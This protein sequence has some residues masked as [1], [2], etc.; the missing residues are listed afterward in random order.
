MR[1]FVRSHRSGVFIALVM[2]LFWIYAAIGVATFLIWDPARTSEAALLAVMLTLV[3]SY[4]FPWA[5]ITETWLKIRKSTRPSAHWDW[6]PDTS[7]PVDEARMTTDSEFG[8]D[9]PK[10]DLIVARTQSG[11]E[12]SSD[13]PALRRHVIG[14]L[15]EKLNRR[16]ES[17]GAQVYTPEEL[18][19]QGYW[20]MLMP[21]VEAFCSLHD[22]ARPITFQ[23]YVDGTW[24]DVEEQ[25]FRVVDPDESTIRLGP[26]LPADEVSIA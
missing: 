24:V 9:V 2:I 25:F 16:Y 26:L 7:R 15:M 23:K 19:R 14:D 10:G 6:L 1:S 3:L 8:T 5:H 21:E 13:D 17:I 20:I 11:N 12:W 4:L 22:I 18:M